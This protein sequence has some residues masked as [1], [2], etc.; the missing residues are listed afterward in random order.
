MLTGVLIYI[1]IA[2]SA[3]FYQDVKKEGK[4]FTWELLYGVLAWPIKA[5]IALVKQI[6]K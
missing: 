4:S 5:I 3:Y 2:L 1:I 6:R